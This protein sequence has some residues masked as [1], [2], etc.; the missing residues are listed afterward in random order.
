MSVKITSCVIDNCKIYVT[1]KN[2]QTALAIDI[3]DLATKVRGSIFASLLKKCRVGQGVKTPPFHGGIT[4]SNPVRGTNNFQSLEILTFRA[5]LF[6]RG[7]LTTYLI[8]LSLI[9]FS[10]VQEM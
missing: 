7:G 2:P 5:F 9:N 3:K 8:T 4:G 6:L 1:N 10:F